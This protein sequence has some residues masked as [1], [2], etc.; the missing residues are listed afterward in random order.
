MTRRT[1]RTA[2]AELGL[3]VL[4]EVCSVGLLG[5]SGWFIATSAVAGAAVFSTFS[6]LAPSGGVRSFALGRIGSTY[7]NRVVLHAAALRRISAARL[8]FY[9]RTAAAPETHGAWSGQS[10]D[11]VMA[12]ADTTGMALI[13]ATAPMVV[14]AA[15]GLVGCLVVALAGLPGVACVIAVGVVACAA[16]A[17]ATT[18]HTEDVTAARGALRRELVT[19]VDAWTE[20]ASL[21]ATDEL[22]ERTLRD[23][24]GYERGRFEQAMIVARSTGI[25]RAVCAVTLAVAVTAAGGTSVATLVFV[26]LLTSGVLASAAGLVPAAQSLMLARQAHRRLDS[27]G[28]DA[29]RPAV[30]AFHASY[31]ARGLT[32]S[33]YRLPAG[34]ARAAGRIDIT[35]RAGQTLVLTGPSG[36]GKTTFLDALGAKLR[37]GG[38]H[39]V[40]SALADDYLFTGTVAGNIRLADPTASDQDVAG[41]LTDLLLDRTGLEP[42]TAVGVHGRDV[43][44]GEARRLHLARALA[45]RPDVLLVDEPTAG[46]D[47]ATATRVLAAIRERLPDAVLVLA[48]HESVAGLSPQDSGVRPDRGDGWTEPLVAGSRASVRV[49]RAATARDA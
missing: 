47:P 44:G 6:Y 42:N 28:R 39:V 5:L 7:A 1:T 35:V 36:S 48:M 15:M 12:D 11:R 29:V 40:T 14:A 25:A 2:Y 49:P 9:D 30:T 38:D 3:A 26:V 27:A 10:L 8:G 17:V 34:A 21:G 41:L 23:L 45:T 18:R 32:V 22:A 13:E 16:L 43:S 31:D 46:L 4:A 19:A 24:A 37:Q 33:G 20:M